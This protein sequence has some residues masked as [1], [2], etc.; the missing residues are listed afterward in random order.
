MLLACLMMMLPLAAEQWVAHH[1]AGVVVL[2]RRGQDGLVKRLLPMVEGEVPRIAGALG[3]TEVHPFPVYA[4]ASRVDFMRH[5]GRQPDLLGAS[6]SPSGEI[7]FD[8]TDR[9]SSTRSILAHE[10]THSLLGQRLGDRLVMLPSWVNEGIAGHLSD[11]V[12]PAQMAGVSRMMHRNGPLTLEELDDAFPDGSYRDAAYLQSR[13]MMAWLE[14]QYPGA[15]LRVLDALERGETFD[16]ALRAAAGLTAEDWVA[17][18]QR[19]VPALFYWMSVL[20]SPVVYSPFALVLVWVAVRRIMRKRS[21]DHA[22]EDEE[23]EE[24]GEEEVGDEEGSDVQDR[25]SP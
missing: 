17:G 24:D 18:W 21:E 15:M 11:P 7:H 22:D 5:T 23:D 13:S 4:Y 8:A 19:N 20:A 10:L 16:A 2:T 6:Y 1:T 25:P 14:Y 3:L 9:R 12:N